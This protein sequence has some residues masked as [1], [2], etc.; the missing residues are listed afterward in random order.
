M[1]RYGA[2]PF[3]FHR[4][5]WCVWLH[6]HWISPM[7]MCYRWRASFCALHWQWQQG[8][9]CDDS[10]YHQ[11]QRT[12]S[13]RR[14]HLFSQNFPKKMWR[15]E[16]PAQ[17]RKE[18]KT[19]QYKKTKHSKLNRAGGRNQTAFNKLEYHLELKFL[20]LEELEGREDILMW[21]CVRYVWRHTACRRWHDWLNDRNYVKR[22]KCERS[23]LLKESKINQIKVRIR[24]DGVGH[25]EWL[26]QLLLHKPFE[27]LRELHSL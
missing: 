4:G 13:H 5:A 2:S 24:L 9:Q 27:R 7:S 3:I 15:E 1:C 23:F 18:K 25:I 17:N 19:V 8:E 16:A 22:R 12:Y 20:V 11:T 10:L 6:A 26:C 21:M 14:R